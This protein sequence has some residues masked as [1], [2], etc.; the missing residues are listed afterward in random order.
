MFYRNVL[1]N[2]VLSYGLDHVYRVTSMES[3]WDHLTRNN[4]PKENY[5]SINRAKNYLRALAFCLI[6]LDKRNLFKDKKKLQ[7]IKVL[8]K[9]TVILNPHKDNGV[10]M[11]VTKTM[12]SNLQ[13]YH[14]KLNNR[15]EISEEVYQEIR[16]KTP[17]VPKAQGLPKVNKSF[18]ILP[19]FRPIIDTI[20]FTHYNAGKYITKLLNR[21]TQNKC[22]HF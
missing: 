4:L 6:D 16:Q 21:F 18:E 3:V 17:K 9:D 14:R 19:S 11:I 2:D 15:S 7:V 13:S 8:H 12:L 1:S 5:H 20:G 22:S 10:P